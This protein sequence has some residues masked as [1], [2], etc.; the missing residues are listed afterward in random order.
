[1]IQTIFY[2]FVLPCFYGLAIQQILEIA[3]LILPF[4]LCRR[5]RKSISKAIAVAAGMV[6][7]VFTPEPAV[8]IGVSHIGKVILTGLITAA[9]AEAA[10]ASIKSLVYTKELRKSEAA[11]GLST[12]GSI[13]L[14]TISRK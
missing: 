14:E 5:Q 13:S 1:M 7:A 6:L 11:D 8:M 3:Y 10:N 9:A 2:L 12:A 4:E